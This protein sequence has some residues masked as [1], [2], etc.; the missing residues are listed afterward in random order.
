MLKIFDAEIEVVA[1]KTE[2]N[3]RKTVIEKA[4]KNIPDHWK[5]LVGKLKVVLFT[6]PVTKQVN[7]DINKFIAKGADWG[8]DGTETSMYPDF[9]YSA[10]IGLIYLQ[11][12]MHYTCGGKGFGKRLGERSDYDIERDFLDS[13]AKIIWDLQEDNTFKN[14]CREK[15]VVSWQSFYLPYLPSFEVLKA[16]N[17]GLRT[18]D[19]ERFR[20]RL[21][22]KCARESFGRIWQL[23]IDNPNYLEEK[24]DIM[25]SK[26][27]ELDHLVANN[28]NVEKSPV[29]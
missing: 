3:Q 13:F 23:F 14:F 8:C 24:M 17:P 28:F 16:H 15:F 5:K 4:Y 27:R 22:D 6:G 18:R 10:K 2:L 19:L 26:I 11:T 25:V 7:K 9:V 12:S 29:V 20:N 1:S 21:R